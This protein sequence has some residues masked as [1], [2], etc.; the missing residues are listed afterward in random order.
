MLKILL[1]NKVQ[2]KSRSTSHISNKVEYGNLQKLQKE[3][4]TTLHI[5]YRFS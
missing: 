2:H 3:K 1:C 5:K 4:Y